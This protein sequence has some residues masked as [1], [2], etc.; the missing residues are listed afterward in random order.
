MINIAMQHKNVI[1]LHYSLDSLDRVLE[2]RL[3]HGAVV[4]EDGRTTAGLLQGG[5][6]SH[7]CRA[8]QLHLTSLTHHAVWRKVKTQNINLD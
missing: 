5:E 3:R 1:L 2:V 8:G 4:D 7:G 6:V